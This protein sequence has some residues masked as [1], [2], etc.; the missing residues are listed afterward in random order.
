VDAVHGEPDKR[1]TLYATCRAHG[2]SPVLVW[3]RC[4][5]ESE[6]ARRIRARRGR[7]HEPEHE[8]ADVSVVRHLAG[9]WR[10]PAGE[11]IPMVVYDTVGSGVAPG[12]GPSAPLADLVAA[13]L[14]PRRRVVEAS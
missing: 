2:A 6:R 10:D 3:C 14:A 11:A 1:A 4:D 13:A 7:E 5:D 8:A 12:A 9:L